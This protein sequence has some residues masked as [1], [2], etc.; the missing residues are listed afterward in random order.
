MYYELSTIKTYHRK[1]NDES[2]SFNQINL[3]FFSEF[4]KDDNIA[5]IYSDDLTR[6]LDENKKYKHELELLKSELDDLSKMDEINSKELENRSQMIDDM[7][8][9]IENLKKENEKYSHELESLKS[10]FDNVSDENEK[11]RTIIANKNNELSEK[12]DNLSD[13]DDE[14]KKYYGYTLA[15][16]TAIAEL[17]SR[18]VIDRARNK[19][20][21][22]YSSIMKKIPTDILLANDSEIKVPKFEKE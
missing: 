22:T 15:L 19:K 9:K 20:P 6:L 12:D 16:T 10:D 7:A 13:K 21:S 8:D 17:N 5:V 1:K 4:K 11:L 2:K 18:G 3:G 14:L